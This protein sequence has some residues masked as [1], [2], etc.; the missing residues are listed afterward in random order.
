MRATGLVFSAGVNR[1]KPPQAP[2]FMLWGSRALNTSYSSIY[3]Q[4]SGFVGAPH[5]RAICRLLGYQVQRGRWGWG[6]GA[7][8]GETM[9][10]GKGEGR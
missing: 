3:G 6:G 5:F 1:E 7:G 10:S 4:Y 8:F 9:R 2:H